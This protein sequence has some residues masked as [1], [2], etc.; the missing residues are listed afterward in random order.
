MLN[1][2]EISSL[3]A[4]GKIKNVFDFLL[5]F[6]N[7]AEVTGNFPSLF[8]TLDGKVYEFESSTIAYKP[9][10]ENYSFLIFEEFKNLLESLVNQKKIILKRKHFNKPRD[11]GVPKMLKENGYSLEVAFI[12]DNWNWFNKEIV[13]IL[14]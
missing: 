11:L 9:Q 5:R 4:E 10:N 1:V 12:E 2:Q 7:L 13:P 6:G 3:I 14:P 8:I